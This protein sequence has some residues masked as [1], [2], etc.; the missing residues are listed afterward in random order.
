MTTTVP[1]SSPAKPIRRSAARPT[2]SSANARNTMRSNRARDTGPELALREVL[3]DAGLRGYRV[4][5]RGAP[6]RPDVAFT[7]QQVAIF[8]HGCFWHR[9]PY[10]RPNLP[11]AN[12]EF[13]REKFRMNKKRDDRARAGLM[14]LGWEVIE[15]WECQI[16]ADLGQS[17][18]KIR[19]AVIKRRPNEPCKQKRSSSA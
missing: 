2:A 1:A 13:W 14:N 4:D 6:G 17:V 15:L 5:Y 8:V 18:A 12:R 9:C 3:R 10:C 19:R 16:K 11:R 7:K